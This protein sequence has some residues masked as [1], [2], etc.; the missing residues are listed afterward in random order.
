MRALFTSS[1][2][3]AAAQ[4]LFDQFDGGSENRNFPNFAFL[5]EAV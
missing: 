5:W 4:V 2:P 3:H 1:D